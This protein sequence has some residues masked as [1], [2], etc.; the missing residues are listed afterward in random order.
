VPHDLLRSGN[1][2]G[3]TSTYGDDT[4]GFRVAFTLPGPVP[5]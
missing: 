1:R 5:K 2:A 3:V 4:I